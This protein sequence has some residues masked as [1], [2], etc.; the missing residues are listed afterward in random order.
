MQQVHLYRNVVRS[1]PVLCTCKPSI[2]LAISSAGHD[3]GTQ[4]IFFCH[5]HTIFRNVCN[6]S[7]TF[8]ADS[9]VWFLQVCNESTYQEVVRATCGKV[10]GVICEVAIAVY[11]FGTCI[12]FFIVI[13]DQLDRC[14]YIHTDLMIHTPVTLFLLRLTDSQVFKVENTLRSFY[15]TCNSPRCHFSELNFV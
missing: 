6:Y 2:C 11:T 3:E 13:G 1:L 15:A 12:A 7:S 4:Y 14:E 10:T 8:T 9:S 5:T